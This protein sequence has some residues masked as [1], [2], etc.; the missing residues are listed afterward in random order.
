MHA[1]REDAWIPQRS[2]QRVE[3]C[4]EYATPRARPDRTRR[5]SLG[6]RPTCRCTASPSGLTGVTGQASVEQLLAAY[7]DAMAALRARG[8]T[9]SA[10]SPVADYAEHLAAWHYRGTLQPQSAVGYDVRASPRH[11][12]TGE[13]NVEAGAA[14][15]EP[16]GSSWARPSGS[17]GSVLL[18]VVFA[19]D[20]RSWGGVRA[21]LRS[22]YARRPGGLARGA[23]TGS[24]CRRGCSRIRWC[25]GSNWRHRPRPIGRKRLG[26]S[27]SCS[28]SAGGKLTRAESTTRVVASLG[29]TLFA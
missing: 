2:V 16:L 23:R 18:A 11:P 9:R 3:K 6:Y 26:D 27:T 13:G 12:R 22:S 5:R 10:N 29:S 25:A 20:L 19:A 17:S 28:S 8:V 4:L 1:H 21:R 7:A 15:H 14:A 24:H